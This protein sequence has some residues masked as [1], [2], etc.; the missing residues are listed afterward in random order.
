MREY[1]FLET[2]ERNDYAN[3]K[4]L[5]F[6]LPIVMDSTHIVETGLGNAHSTHIF[7][8][9]LYQLPGKRQLTTIEKAADAS[10]LLETLAD[11]H[12][13]ESYYNRGDVIWQLINGEAKDVYPHYSI[14]LPA[15]DF[16]YLDSDH[17]YD[18]VLAELNM[19]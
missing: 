15:I 6:T 10:I 8:E 2:R 7:L 18:N 9:A 17:K 12:K 1:L 19:F 16:L 4:Y 11:T 14:H 3:Y 5:M 13:L